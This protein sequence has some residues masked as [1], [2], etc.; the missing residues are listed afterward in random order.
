MSIPTTD[1]VRP[2]RAPPPARPAATRGAVPGQGQHRVQTVTSAAMMPSTSQDRRSGC[3]PVSKP[4]TGPMRIA[5]TTNRVTRPPASAGREALRRHEVGHAPEQREHHHREL[6]AH[7]AEEAQSRARAPPHRPA[8]GRRSPGPDRRAG[9]Q[10]RAARSGRRPGSAPR[11]ARW[12]PRP[13][14]NAVVQPARAAGRGTAR[15]RGSGRSGPG[16]RS[17]G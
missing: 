14:P 16:C 10:A 12:P 8:P 7:V 17:A 1:P 13:P 3:R 11:P 5:Q 9:V 2:R 4:M 6:G 15:P